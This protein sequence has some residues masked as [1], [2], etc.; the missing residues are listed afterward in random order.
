M[1]Q[2]NYY[3]GTG[4]GLGALGQAVDSLSTP[5]KTSVM[6]QPSAARSAWALLSTASGAICAFHGYRR[7][8]G[9]IGWTIGWF[10]LGN[11]FPVLVPA[12][13]LAQGFGKP[14]LS[15]NARRERS[16]Q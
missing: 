11:A 9:S 4:L 5:D 2:Q 10:L 16:R 8:R 13:A 14:A 7:N 12:I 15:Q 1:Q 3:T 6:W